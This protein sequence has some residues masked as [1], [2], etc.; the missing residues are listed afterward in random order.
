[1]L[2][3]GPNLSDQATKIVNNGKP[4]QIP[5]DK[6]CLSEPVKCQGGCKECFCS[7][8][9]MKYSWDACH[10]VLCTGN[11]TKQNQQQRLN[12]M[13]F[14]TNQNVVRNPDVQVAARIFARFICLCQNNPETDINSLWI[15]TTLP[16][17]SYWSEVV[18][19]CQK[20]TLGN[21][22]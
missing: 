17:K 12:L 15:Q 4:L 6:K 9:C 18:Y 1:M 13:K 10:K 19:E 20:I 7:E 16:Y 8:E 22:K 11:K 5:N 14:F 3:L 21:E 2:F